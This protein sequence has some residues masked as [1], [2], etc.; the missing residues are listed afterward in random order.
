V[1]E[2]IVKNITTG[3]SRPRRRDGLLYITDISRGRIGHP[4]KY[5]NSNQRINVVVLT[6][7]RTKCISLGLKQLTL[8][9]WE[10]CSP[11]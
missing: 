9:P 8:H 2:G 4:M 1:L 11:T 10:G 5:R 7:M 6:S 3:H